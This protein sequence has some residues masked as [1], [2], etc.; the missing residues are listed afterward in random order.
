MSTEDKKP[1]DILE[2][3]DED[4]LK[5]ASFEEMNAQTT[6]EEVV[7]EQSETTEETPTDE[8]ASNEQIEGQEEVESATETSSTTSEESSSEESETTL[9]YKA[10][11]EKILKPFKANG[12]EIQVKTLD[13][14]IALMQM[15]ANYNKKMVG[16]KPSL[17]VL[18][19]LEQNNLL[20]ESKLNFLID[21]DKK[22]PDAISKLIKDSGIDPFELNEE[23]T[24]AYQPTVR[25]IDDQTLELDLVLEELKDTP[26]YVK[27]MEVVGKIWD[28]PSRQAL[29]SQ[30][31]LLKVINDHV[32]NGVY[33]IINT[34]MERERMFG[35]L[36]GL[37]DLDAYRKIGDAIQAQGGFNH[38]GNQ[39]P[40]QP[41][42]VAPKPKAED[43]Q[44]KDKRRA[45][46][47]TPAATKTTVKADFN[48]LALS[49]DEFNKLSASQFL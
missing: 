13:D 5:S 33:D 24:A 31:Q 3:S 15:G 10:E 4:F 1:L 21:L 6:S 14:A 25:A 23:K 12:K 35:R 9:D 26:T 43:T 11:Y 28:G 37:S 32:A 44:L 40:T 7:E 27:T 22:N 46:S 41:V 38:I 45:A 42:K 49:D 48:P 34:E 17:K 29:A 20:D 19:L 30:P 39:T 2:M 8:L 47:V 16:L 18:K 36:E